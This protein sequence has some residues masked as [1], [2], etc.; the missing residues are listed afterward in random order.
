MENSEIP[1]H[2]HIVTQSLTHPSLSPLTH[3]LS[4]SPPTPL[5]LSPSHPLSL[6]LTLSV[7]SHPLTFSSTHPLT[8]SSSH[9]LA[10][11]LT[12]TEIHTIMNL[13]YPFTCSLTHNNCNIFFF[14]DEYPKAL[15]LLS[16]LVHTDKYSQAGVWL[17][18]AEC[19]HMLNDLEAAASSY[20]K[21]I[22][23]APN[24]T[25]TRWK[26]CYLYRYHISSS[27]ASP[28][29][30]YLCRDRSLLIKHFECSFGCLLT[31]TAVHH[32]L[33]DASKSWTM[34]KTLS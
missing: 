30:A 16:A 9:P 22:S 15:P 6:S 29:P 25:D 8:H 24:H 28:Q 27:F 7:T 5:T 21:V 10:H 32:Q 23:L 4:Q 18:Y 14:S 26:S 17:K 12:L 33:Q 1:H 13:T 11:T 34:F 3:S 19:Q 2:L 31:W 20:S